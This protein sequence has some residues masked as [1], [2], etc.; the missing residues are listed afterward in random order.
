MVQSDNIRAYY[1][2]D[3]L[4]PERRQNH[5]FDQPTIFPRRARLALGLGMLRKK[6]G[7]EVRDGRRLPPGRSISRWVRS[8]S[9]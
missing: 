5:V 2:G 3:A 6:P 8:A 1:I 7:P 9:N 4:P